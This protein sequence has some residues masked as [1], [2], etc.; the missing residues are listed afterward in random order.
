MR[1]NCCIAVSP[2]GRY[3][4]RHEVA[5]SSESLSKKLL[6]VQDARVGQRCAAF[7]ERHAR[8]RSERFSWN[9]AHAG[10]GP[11]TPKV[12]HR[13]WS[14]APDAPP[15]LRRW[16]SAPSRRAYIYDTRHPFC[17]MALAQPQVPPESQIPRSLECAPCSDRQATTEFTLGSSQARFSKLKNAKNS[18]N[19]CDLAGIFVQALKHF[20][21]HHIKPHYQPAVSRIC[22]CNSP[23]SHDTLLLFSTVY[24]TASGSP[25]TILFRFAKPPATESLTLTLTRPRLS[26]AELVFC[27]V[28]WRDAHDVPV[29]TA[30]LPLFLDTLR[31]ILAQGGNQLQRLTFTQCVFEDPRQLAHLAETIRPTPHSCHNLRTLVLHGCSI[32]TWPARAPELGLM[33]PQVWSRLI[34]VDFSRVPLRPR[35]RAGA[36]RVHQGYLAALARVEL[37]PA[38]A[39]V[40]DAVRPGRRVRA[41][42]G[43]AVLHAPRGA[44]ALLQGRAWRALADVLKERI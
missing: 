29:T 1:R 17:N 28:L 19:S 4:A 37:E 36:G 33:R 26:L 43:P 24:W 44:R 30:A 38:A 18:T 35:A 39:V 41:A 31:P 27:G 25:H 22:Y 7:R 20:W 42:P 23:L 32:L 14:R 16:R 11:A 34:V 3:R 15:Q 2:T 6:P 5:S 40:A 13:F 21:A 9:A 10:L 8:K 12:R